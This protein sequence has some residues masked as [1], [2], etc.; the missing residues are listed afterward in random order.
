MRC[1]VDLNEAGVEF[2]DCDPGFHQNLWIYSDSKFGGNSF[3]H[4]SN[5]L[6]YFHGEN[7]LSM[8]VVCQKCECPENLLQRLNGSSQ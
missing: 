3:L 5:L 8:K 4:L 1:S 7:V 2:H 6:E